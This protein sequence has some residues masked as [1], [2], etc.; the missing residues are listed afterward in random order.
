[1]W[2]SSFS[3]SCIYHLVAEVYRW[4]DVKLLRYTR[5]QAST[6]VL[7][8]SEHHAGPWGDRSEKRR[9]AHTPNSA[10]CE[11]MRRKEISSMLTAD[12]LTCCKMQL[13]P[14]V[15]PTLKYHKAC[16]LPPRVGMP[17]N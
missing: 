15:G 1:M 6:H 7:G 13:S 17:L 16:S 11:R 2:P 10:K 4:P 3:L 14:L 8:T 5:T 12:M 9:P